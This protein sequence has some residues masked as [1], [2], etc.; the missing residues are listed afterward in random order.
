MDLKLNANN[1]L[2]F[3][4]SAWTLIDGQ[5]AIAQS[6]KMRLKTWFGE[7]GTVY[8]TSQGVPYLE[9][10]FARGTASATIVFILKG[11]VADTPGVIQADLVIL[12]ED[13]ENRSIT[14]KG[15]ATTQT[16]PLDFTIILGTDGVSVTFTET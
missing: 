10:I 13:R 4:D 2:D 16:E 9:V 3:T 14:L 11:V 15:T 5:E 6:I 1:D 7:A 12:N 8:D